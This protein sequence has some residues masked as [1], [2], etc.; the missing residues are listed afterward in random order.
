MKK[1]LSLTLALALAFPAF[2]A[3]SNSPRVQGVPAGYGDPV[4]VTIVDGSGSPS[5]A[6]VTGN[7]ASGATDSGNPVKI[8]CKY[9]FTAPSLSDSQRVDCQSDISGSIR[10]RNML[11]Q[12]TGVD[13]FSNANVGY[14]TASGFNTV[15]LLTATANSV[16]NGTSWDRQRGN[17]D[18]IF[19]VNAPSA[20]SA[21]AITPVVTSAVASNLVIK[22]S[23]GNLYAVNI[24]TGASAGYLMIFNATSAPADG[25]VTPVKCLP[26]AANTGMELSYRS[27]PVAFSTGI[28]AVFSTTGCFSK[29]A[30]ATAFISGDAK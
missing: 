27:L 3:P 30:S 17:T 16:F 6:T 21:V 2:A 26:V 22:G 5:G 25:A 11:G 4:Q 29:T 12:V 8:G 13:T 10:T 20:A 23:A 28:T 18:G 15:N 14:A 9:L 7:V 24:T 19:T 1:V